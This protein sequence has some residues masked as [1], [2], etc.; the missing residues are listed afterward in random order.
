MGGVVTTRT[1]EVRAIPSKDTYDLL[2]NVHYAGR[3]PSI[4]FAFGLFVDGALEGV[5][6]FGS[7][8]TSPVRKGLMGAEHAHRVLELNRLCLRTNAY[9]DASYLV[10]AALRRLPPGRAVLSFAD[11]AQGHTGAVYQA[12]NFV[13]CGLSAKR[14]DWKIKGLE[15]LH[16]QSIVDMFK[17]RPDRA[18]AARERFG[19]D[20]KLVAR[21]RKHRYVYFTGDRRERKL[22]LSAL[23]YPVLPYPKA[24]GA[25]TIGERRMGRTMTDATALV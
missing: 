4:S 15:H 12:T 22:M 8:A 2:L 11:S 24:G 5:C 6:T 1:R 16:N 19:D 25:V 20:F 3:I 7:P 13:Y 9:N 23:K 10:A 14:T 17:D 18:A 21:P